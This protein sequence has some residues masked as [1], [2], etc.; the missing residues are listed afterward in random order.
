MPL[1]GRSLWDAAQKFREHINAVLAHTI[2]ATPVQ[3]VGTKRSQLIE[4]AF[5]QGGVPTSARLKTR[6]GQMWLSFGQTCDAVAQEGVYRLRTVKY[7]YTLTSGIGNDE[8]PTGEP[9]LRWE[10]VRQPEPGVAAWCRH[11]LQGPVQ[12]TFNREEQVLNALHLPT[13]YVPFEEIIRFCIVDL[14]VSGSAG[15]EDILN[16]SYETF[17]ADFIT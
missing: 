9:V 1:T 17:K 5:R 3:V 4:I 10:Y 2:T 7:K 8:P 15:W 11:H 12:V 16:Q 13:G 6:F 14:G